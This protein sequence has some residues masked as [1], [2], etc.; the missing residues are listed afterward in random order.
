M[1]QGG[2]LATPPPEASSEFPGQHISE[3]WLRGEF[4]TGLAYG[5]EPPKLVIKRAGGGFT[6]EWIGDGVLEQTQN[7]ADRDAWTAV[8]GNPN[9][10]AITSPAGNVYYRLTR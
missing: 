2:S 8:P 10:Y 5:G 4:V 3:A 6:I 1:S 7:I 9:P